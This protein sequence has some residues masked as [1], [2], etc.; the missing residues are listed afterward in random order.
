S[1]S[2]AML[3][4]PEA[5][6]RHSR[7]RSAEES[8]RRL[9]ESS[10]HASHP[11]RD[12]KYLE[13]R[14]R[15]ASAELRCGCDCARKNVPRRKVPTNTCSILSVPPAGRYHRDFPE[16]AGLWLQVATAP[17]PE[18]TMPSHPADASNY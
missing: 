8:R 16:P 3:R 17:S 18:P 14:N 1:L 4:E 12:R 11:D 7:R 5:G 13:P 6:W 10:S 2:D 9:P 15:L